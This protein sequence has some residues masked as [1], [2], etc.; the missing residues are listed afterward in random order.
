MEYTFQSEAGHLLRVALSEFQ[1]TLYKREE[2]QIIPYSA[3]TDVRL[4]R[5]NDSYF[6]EI[7]SLDFGFIRIFCRQGSGKEAPYC[8]FV[9]KL[10]EQLI[11]NKCEADF[12]AGF[13]RKD[14]VKRF[15][16]FSLVS[17]LIFLIEDYYDFLPVSDL[18]VLLILALITLL[19]VG[20]PLVLNRGETYPPS[21]I[22]IRFL[23]PRT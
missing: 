10:H 16:F 1:L 8:R 9:Q 19:A 7:N 17:V 18:S 14:S 15:L 6:T 4:F 3:I 22:P 5:K 11:R 20:I 12:S 13:R 2:E 21:K 23:P